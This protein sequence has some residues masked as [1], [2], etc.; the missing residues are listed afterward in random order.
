MDFLV[1]RLNQGDWV[2]IFPEGERIQSFIN[3]ILAK[4]F[5]VFRLKKKEKKQ[6]VFFRE[7]EHDRG[8]YQVKMG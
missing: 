8:V 6:F 4:I 7:G 1:E 3:K 5:E 2:H